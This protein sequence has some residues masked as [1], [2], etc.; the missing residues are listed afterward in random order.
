MTISLTSGAGKTGHQL[1]KNE[2]HTGQW[3]LSAAPL[4]PRSTTEQANL[5]KKPPPLLVSGWKLDTEET[6]KQKPNTQRQPLQ[7][8]QEQQTKIPVVNTDYTGR[9]L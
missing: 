8:W 4:P 9:G 5:N 3:R 2:T 6:S 1:W 7:K